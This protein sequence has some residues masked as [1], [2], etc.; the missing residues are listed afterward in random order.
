[1]RGQRALGQF[2][3]RQ[4]VDAF[5][6]EGSTHLTPDLEGRIAEFTGIGRRMSGAIRRVNRAQRVPVNATYTHRTVARQQAAL[7]VMSDGQWVRIT[8]Q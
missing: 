1:V 6:G 7:L 4:I 8:G 2:A 5:L 3:R